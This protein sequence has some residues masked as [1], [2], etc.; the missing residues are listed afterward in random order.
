MHVSPLTAILGCCYASAVLAS[1][2]DVQAAH[3]WWRVLAPGETKWALA[4]VRWSTEDG[5]TLA[6]GHP[7]SSGDYAE[8]A[9]AAQATDLNDKTYWCESTKAESP[10]RW[11]G[12]RFEGAEAVAA[13]ELKQYPHDNYKSFFAELQHSDDEGATWTTAESG[14]LTGEENADG[15]PTWERIPNLKQFDQLDFF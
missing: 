1:K 4:E 13:V 7:F 10:D 8:W 5:A 6:G 15:S 12:V 3:K 11:L 14:D 9:N 2:D